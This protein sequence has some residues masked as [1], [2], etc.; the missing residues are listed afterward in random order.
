MNQISEDEASDVKSPDV[1]DI[2]SPA[3][4]DS[5][6]D[7]Q[8]KVRLQQLDSGKTDVSNAL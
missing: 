7:S 3:S 8:A 6:Q 2:I 4:Q 1:E 5:R